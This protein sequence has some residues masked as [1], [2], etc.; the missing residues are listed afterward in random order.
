MRN[1]IGGFMS[2]K[3]KKVEF[4]LMVKRWYIKEMDRLRAE[5]KTVDL[6][7]GELELEILAEQEMVGGLK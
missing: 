1:I 3:E 7:L 5:I 2:D 6:E 4:L